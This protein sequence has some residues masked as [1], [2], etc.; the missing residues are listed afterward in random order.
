M[1][2]GISS[3]LNIRHDLRPGDIGY[4]I[5]LHGLL[6]ADEFGWDHTFEAYVA[7]PL[8]EFCKSHTA[9]DRIWIV[10]KEGTVAGSIGIV[11]A[12]PERAQLRWFLLHPDLRGH[13]LGRKLIEQA[14]QFCRDC[15]Y[16]LVYLWTTSELRA[17][18]S[19]YRS[20]GFHLMEEKT[21]K[22]LGA[23]VTEQRYELRL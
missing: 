20:G 15:Q 3:P 9:R 13:G 14:I 17:A 12:A 11:E 10:E 1:N 19:L 21:H 5:F 18:A 2:E 23:M 22:I 16:S 6:Y 8:A 4:L 7:G